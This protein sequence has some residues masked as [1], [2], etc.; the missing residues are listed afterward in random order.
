M[1][2]FMSK[3]ELADALLRGWVVDGRQGGLIVGR[4]HSEGHIVMIQPLENG[5]CIFAGLVEGGEY[6]LSPE[7]TSRHLE[8]LKEINSDTSD[9]INEP[10]LSRHSRLL[11]T[12]AEPH[13]KLLLI[14]H[15][16][17]VNINATNRYFQELESLNLKTSFAL[18]QWL[19]NDF[20]EHL[21]SNP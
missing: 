7:A 18:S 15:Q 4:R 6:L 5:D 10:S 19:P 1:E 12:S 14:A 2:I 13:D 20:I 16:M 8:R 21:K 17:I 9:C 11:S 3:A